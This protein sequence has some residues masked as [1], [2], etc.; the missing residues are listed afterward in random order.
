MQ[1]LS[2]QLPIKQLQSTFIINLKSL[3]IFFTSYNKICALR[4]PTDLFELANTNTSLMQRKACTCRT[5][6]SHNGA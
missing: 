4:S 5:L 3:S 2:K 1:L 6:E